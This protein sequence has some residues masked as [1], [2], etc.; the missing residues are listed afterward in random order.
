MSLPLAFL[1]GL[2]ATAIEGSFDLA[3]P[4]DPS[5][6]RFLVFAPL[7]LVPCAYAVIVLPVLL[8]YRLRAAGIGSVL[9]PICHATAAYGIH[10]NEFA[11]LHCA[12]SRTLALAIVVGP[13]LASEFALRCAEQIVIARARLGDFQRRCLA[14]LGFA[15]LPMVAFVCTSLAVCIVA[16]EL[17]FRRRA[18]EVFFAETSL[19]L[20]LG[21]GMLLLLVAVLLPLMIRAFLPIRALPDTLASAVAREAATRLGFPLRAVKLLDTGHREINAA[22]IGP[23]PWPRYLV[24]SDGLLDYFLQDP[25]PL[26]GVVAHEVGHARAHHPAW[27]VVCVVVLPILWLAPLMR[28]LPESTA[29]LWMWPWWMW[30]TVALGVLGLAYG[31]RRLAH[32]FEHEADQLSSEVLGGASACVT[33]LRRVGDLHSNRHRKRSSLRHPSEEARVELMLRNE[34]DEGARERFWRHGRILRSVLVACVL[35]SVGFA[36]HAHSRTW[37]LDRVRVTFAEGRFA[38]A[39]TL[40]ERIDVEQLGEAERRDHERLAHKVAA[41]RQI[42]PDGGPWPE[43]RERLAQG[44]RERGE[45]L[46]AQ[47]QTKEDAERAQIWF[48]LAN[49]GAVPDARLRTLLAWCAAK[50]QGRDAEALALWE[51]AQ[52]LR[53]TQ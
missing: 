16:T 9:V 7:W 10:L 30:P 27:L 39:S 33:A 35:V 21:A 40:L 41:A 32:R 19:G 17:L 8:P 31:L 1:L 6:A 3:L 28:I 11:N 49:D 36:A 4:E 34:R 48:E 29:S 20:T 47:G 15:R 13:L 22:L 38:T 18:L 2:L 52:A 45:A 26:R 24:L 50:T 12:G 23:L 53:R 51:H 5:L 37:T 43:I 46:L 14:N 25:Q 44:A 42:V